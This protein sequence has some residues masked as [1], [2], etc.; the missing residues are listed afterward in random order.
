MKITELN[1]DGKLRRINTEDFEFTTLKKLYEQN[2]KDK[3]YSLLSLF[4]NTKSRFGDAPILI[5]QDYLIN[6][7]SFLLDTAR[8]IMNDDELCESINNDKVLFTIEEFTNKN[9]VGYSVKWSEKDE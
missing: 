8:T 2:G 4:I 6:A 1:H 9:G 7:P 3:Q 5:I